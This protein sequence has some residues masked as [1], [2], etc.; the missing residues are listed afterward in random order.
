M[1]LLVARLELI[2]PVLMA[3][4]LFLKQ[5]FQKRQLQHFSLPSV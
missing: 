4:R 3:S 1:G 5:H 2:G